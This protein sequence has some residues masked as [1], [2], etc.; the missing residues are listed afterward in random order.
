MASVQCKKTFTE[1][2]GT[3][4]S[5]NYSNEMKP[6]K[7]SVQKCKTKLSK[8]TTLLEFEN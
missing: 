3:M 5:E 1:N 6:N 2:F 8:C 7:L 4:Q